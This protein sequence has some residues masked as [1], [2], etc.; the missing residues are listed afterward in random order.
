MIIYNIQHGGYEIFGKNFDQVTFRQKC[1]QRTDFLTNR[2][3]GK[4]FRRSVVVDEASFFGTFH[5][6]IKRGIGGSPPQISKM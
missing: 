2:L 1:I 3:F 4:K 5:G 6:Q